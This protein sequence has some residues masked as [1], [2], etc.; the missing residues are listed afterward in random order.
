MLPLIQEECCI[1]RSRK[2]A[3]H[4]DDATPRD[5]MQSH[6][7]DLSS[8][9]RFGSQAA[10]GLCPS[11]FLTRSFRHQVLVAMHD[12]VYVFELGTILDEKMRGK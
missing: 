8:N 7:D 9:P 12:V 11:E 6:K 1:T 2:N 5:G 3:S 10:D 4:T